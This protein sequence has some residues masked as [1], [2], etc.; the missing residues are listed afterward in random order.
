MD[1]GLQGKHAIVTRGRRGIGNAI[2]REAARD[3]VV[4]ALTHRSSVVVGIAKKAYERGGS[5]LIRL[6]DQG[7]RAVA[8]PS[9]SHH[10]PR[11]F[12]R[13]QQPAA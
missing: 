12:A 4:D 3:G 2:A 5:H 9:P 7:L 13:A 10:G 1:L 11:P 6:M 8:P